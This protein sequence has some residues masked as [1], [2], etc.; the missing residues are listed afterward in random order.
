MR[1]SRIFLLLVLGFVI[2]ICC[3]PPDFRFEKPREGD[4]ND[5]AQNGDET[6]EDCGGL[7]CPGCEVGD[8]CQAHSD[9][10]N[11][12]CVQRV[13]RAAHCTDGDISGSETYI[14]CGGGECPPCGV[15]QRCDENADCITH[16]CVDRECVATDCDDRMLSP[17]ETSIDCGGEVCPAC[18]VGERC[19]GSGDC[20]TGL[21]IDD[22]CTTEACTDQMKGPTEEG[23]DCGGPCPF[24]CDPVAA[25][26]DN[27]KGPLESDID[28]GGDDCPPCGLGD[29]CEVPG[30]C[31][32]GFCVG[33][34]CTATECPDDALE[35]CEPGAGGAGGAP[36][37]GGA[38]GG[39]AGGADGGAP[40]EGGAGGAAGE[41]GASPQGGTDP[42]GG[43]GGI[44]GGSGAGGSGGTT[45]GA[46][47]GGSATGGT[48]PVLTSCP[49]CAKLSVPL[50]DG[51]DRGGNFVLFLGQTLDFSSARVH[52]R[53]YR[54]TG[55]GGV[56][57]GYVQHSGTPDYQQLFQR[58]GKNLEDLH[59]WQTLTFDVGGHQTTFDKT[60]VARVGIQITGFEGTE[61]KTPAIVY[62][63]SISL[64]GAGDSAW[65]FDHSGTVVYSWET[66]A[67]NGILFVNRGDNPADG[68]SL[69]WL[70][71]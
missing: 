24:E 56:I 53:V 40:P 31:E 22:R 43:S 62:L 45:G 32:S 8:P 58:D 52:Y 70:G 33:L 65:N 60:I 16:A 12:S 1:A 6:G 42:V 28:C 47:T 59:G 71:P 54:E 5:R 41:A 57:K 19:Q 14:D 50:V 27:M 15:R 67:S 20:K 46:A 68:T 64:E 69:N 34:V 48:P 21:C 36:S 44:T 61:P 30:D 17:G 49:G 18:D 55:T 23:V 9:C 3:S 26:S 63:D 66:S 25:C 10:A 4:C 29:T 37:A 51:S 35:G 11:G 38:A 7:S 13:C 2:A 39:G